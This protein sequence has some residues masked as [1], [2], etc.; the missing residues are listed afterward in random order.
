MAEIKDLGIK[1]FSDGARIEDFR[2]M[3]KLPYIKGFTTNPSLMKKAGVSNYI[4]FIEEV[5]DII[6]DKPISLEV[7]SDDFQEMREQ[8]LKLSGYGEN[9]Y[10]KIPIMNTKKESS[11]PLIKELSR[12]GVKVNATALLAQSQVEEV[13][14]ALNK[15]TGAI[16]S[17]FA[18]R[19]ADTGLDP[20]PIM[21]NAHETLS[22]MPNVELLWGSSRELLNIFQAQ[23]AGCDIITVIPDILKKLPLIDH[24]LLDLS[25]KTVNEFFRDALS[26]E[27]IL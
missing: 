12:S 23:E 8:A 11:I 14:R 1:I 5:L 24:D 17:V 19:I 15:E 21:K 16:V 25:H 3:C 9:I 10:V 18:G 6:G 27:L 26:S 7:I 13:A 4:R 2:E 22:S 20:V